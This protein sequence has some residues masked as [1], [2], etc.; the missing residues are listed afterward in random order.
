MAEEGHGRDSVTKTISGFLRLKRRKRPF[1][2]PFFDQIWSNL[3]KFGH[4]WHF[5]GF[6]PQSSR[7]WPISRKTVFFGFFATISRKTVFFGF[8]AISRGLKRRRVLQ[9]VILGL[10]SRQ[11]VYGIA[12]V[13]TAR[14][15][16]AQHACTNK[17]Q[18]Q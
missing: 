5:W 10:S 4:F 18:H 14:E 15:G 17:P 12:L 11:E 7:K 9:K 6:P 8:F 16:F 13:V 1:L 2:T 3:T